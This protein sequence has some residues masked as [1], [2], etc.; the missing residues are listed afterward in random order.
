M[1]EL[2]HDG[3]PEA[4]QHLLDVFGDRVYGLCLRILGSEEDAKDA[5]QETFL[6]VWAKWPSFK[7]RGHFSSWIY[8]IAAN[9]AYMKLRKLRSAREFL[10]E[11]PIDQY[12]ERPELLAPGLGIS[13]ATQAPDVALENL[14]LRALMQQAVDKLSPTYRTAYILKDLERM[15]IKDI[16]EIMELG[17]AA[18]KSRVHRARLEMRRTF[19]E[20]LEEL[21]PKS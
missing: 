11:G 21:Y 16:A 12:E 19:K 18:V 9:R 7:G 14:E 13:G 17:E 4:A 6:S 15:S 2:L 5:V 3:R 20:F 1:L 8:R 10:Q